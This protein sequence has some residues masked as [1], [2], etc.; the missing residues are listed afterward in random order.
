MTIMGKVASL[1]NKAEKCKK[2]I[3][4]ERDKLRDIISDLE[5][6]IES[7]DNAVD[8]LEDIHRTMESAADALSQFL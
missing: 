1:L 3:Q 2:A 8:S 7:C 6:I 5:A 4:G